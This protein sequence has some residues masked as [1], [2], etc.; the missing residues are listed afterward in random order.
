[1][2]VIKVLEKN[3]EADC[4]RL[5]VVGYALTPCENCR[6]GAAQRLLKQRVAPAWLTE[7]C[8]Y[9][10]GEDCRELVEKA[11]GPVRG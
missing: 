1:M 6:F 4:S 2:D 5:G 8:R 7:E 10:S 9:D 11:G 3:P